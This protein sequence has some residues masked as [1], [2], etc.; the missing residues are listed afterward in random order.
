M[1]VEQIDRFEQNQKFDQYLTDK[2]FYLMKKYGPHQ[3]FRIYHGRGKE[4]FIEDALWD[5]TI[6]HLAPYK[7]IF[8]IHCHSWDDSYW[9]FYDRI[10]ASLVSQ[11]SQCYA[12]HFQ[13]VEKAFLFS[14]QVRTHLNCFFLEQNIPSTIV[15]VENQ[16]RFQLS[17]NENQNIGLFFD[18]RSGREWVQNNSK[19]KSV[20]NLFSYTC[21]FSLYALLGNARNVVNMD[22]S[23]TSIHLGRKNHSLNADLLGDYANRVQFFSHDILKSMGKIKK[24]GPYD[25]IIVDPPSFQ[26]SFSMKKDLP[27]LLHRLKELINVHGLLFLA[28][29]NPHVHIRDCLL[30][31]GELLGEEFTLLKLLS[32]PGEFVENHIGHGLKILIYQKVL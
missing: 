10:K 26:N 21:S 19:N 18:M 30:E 15:V 24:L 11:L 23:Q 22:M 28:I 31:Y 17:L 8:N 3:C 7:L 13:A 27:W 4:L 32:A 6:D 2:L 1:F 16:L 29:N 9:S 20:L 25:L 14:V 5:F 12:Q